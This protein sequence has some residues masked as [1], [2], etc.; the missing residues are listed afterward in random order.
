MER[1]DREGDG[2]KSLNGGAGE[3]V[4]VGEV[5]GD[6]HPERIMGLY[7]DGDRHWLL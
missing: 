3:D 5:A 6:G 7:R 4:G 1:R 2:V